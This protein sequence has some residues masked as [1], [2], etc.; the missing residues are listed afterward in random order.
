M[1]CLNCNSSL[2]NEYAYCASCGQKTKV[3]RISIWTIITDF[4]SNLFNFEAKIWQS[5]KDIWVPARL[6]LAYIA[7]QRAKYYNPIRF[8]LVVLLASIGII[9]SQANKTIKKLDER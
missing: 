8:F 5:L 9:V 6:T 4:F 7:G 1:R 3:Q 2:S